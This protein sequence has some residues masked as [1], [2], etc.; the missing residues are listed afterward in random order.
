MNDQTLISPNPDKDPKDHSDSDNSLEDLSDIQIVTILNGY[1]Q[2]AENARE[3][4]RG[5]RD[6]IWEDNIDLYWNRFDFSDKQ[7]W[8]ANEVLPE[9]PQF[10][11][12]FA[13]TM[14]QSLTRDGEF[15]TVEHPADPNGDISGII[16][17]LMDLFFS[18]CGRNATGHPV[19]F[20][21][22]FEDVMKLAA[23]M[24]ACNAV[25]YKE[26]DGEGYV[27]VDVVD[28]REFY[29]DPTGRGLYRIKR[30]Y[31]DLH[32][33]EALAQLKNSKG[34]SIY[35]TENIDKLKSFGQTE[36]KEDRETRAGHG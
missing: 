19:E 35:N 30:T 24:A 8:Q 2:E 36:D 3:L 18:R 16:K 28:P 9:A 31:M 20:G 27:A 5:Q 13:A 6:R 33:L 22:V 23:M 10:V 4:S 32:E 12:R 14:R 21:S 15:F 7:N 34:E 17:K 11:N 29:L 26:R 25:T 1:R